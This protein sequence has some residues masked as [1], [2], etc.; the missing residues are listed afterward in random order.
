M[1]VRNK[2]VK[3]EKQ[4]TY[5]V[6]V[7]K[8]NN[9]IIIYIGSGRCG[10]HQHC[11]SGISHV[12]ELN[13]MHFNGEEVVV[14][15]IVAS[16]DKQETLDLEKSLILKHRPKL[17]KT[18]LEGSKEKNRLG[19][20]W[21]CIQ[22]NIFK[23]INEQT[24]VNKLITR[25]LVG[26]LNDLLDTFPI[27]KLEHGVKMTSYLEVGKYYKSWRPTGKYLIFNQMFQN[28]GLVLKFRPEF[29]AQMRQ[30]CDLQ[31]QEKE[32]NV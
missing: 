24:L 31:E 5:E 15:V 6:Y 2:R 28:T 12:Y 13:K 29:L 18:W 3:K 21:K 8:D 7:V 25:K 22:T 27:S 30:I 1:N 11:K 32:N 10:R 17:N 9:G 26:Q 19:L 4:Q 20:Q 16:F 14:E 23:W